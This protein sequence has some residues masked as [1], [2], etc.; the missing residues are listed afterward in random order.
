MTEMRKKQCAQ[1]PSLPLAPVVFR[2]R[3]SRPEGLPPSRAARRPAHAQLV[4]PRADRPSPVN[5]PR[6]QRTAT[7]RRRRSRRSAAPATAERT[8]TAA[9]SPMRRR[10]PAPPLRSRRRSR[11]TSRCAALPA[12]L[13]AHPRPRQHGGKSLAR[14][15]RALRAPTNRAALPVFATA[16]SFAAP[17]LAEHTPPFVPAQKRLAASESEPV[18]CAWGSVQSRIVDHRGQGATAMRGN[19]RTAAAAAA[20][21]CCRRRRLVLPPLH[22]LS[23]PCLLRERHRRRRCC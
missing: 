13:A 2:S 22:L 12:R 15:Q 11:T 4:P 19:V 1:S 10:C 16:V 20:A 5:R 14:R 6:A 8:A 7:S 3:S 23:R 18:E 21:S 9:S 17:Q